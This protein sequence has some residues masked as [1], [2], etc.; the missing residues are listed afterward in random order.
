MWSS[1][2]LSASPSAWL[3]ASI[4]VAS[5][6]EFLAGQEAQADAVEALVAEAT[7]RLEADARRL[8]TLLREA[9]DEAG[10]VSLVAVWA[11][12]AFLPSFRRQAS[13]ALG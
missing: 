2:C 9:Q 8:G 7:T 5:L 11:A 6:N 12:N 3:S 13:D 10:K 4:F 1:I